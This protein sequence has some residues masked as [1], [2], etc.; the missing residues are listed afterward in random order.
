MKFDGTD[1]TKV[2]YEQ[3]SDLNLLELSGKE[4]MSLLCSLSSEAISKGSIKAW[5][6]FQKE[7]QS[8]VRA[9]I[10]LTF[11]LS[12]DQQHLT[13][14]LKFLNHPNLSIRTATLD[15]LVKRIP[16]KLLKI[17]PKLLLNQDPRIQS[18]A[19]KGLG[20]INPDYAVEYID[21]ILLELDTAN[22]LSA[23]RICILLPFE[24]VKRSL[25]R[26]VAIEKDLELIKKC[27]TILRNNPDI[28][29]PYR[30]WEI[31]E[32]SEPE[33]SELLKTI[34]KGTC[35]NLKNSGIL[36]QNFDCFLRDLQDRVNLSKARKFIQNSLELMENTSKEHFI[37]LKS[38][39]RTALEIDS[40][41]QAL[42][43]QEEW[44]SET[45]RQKLM[46]LGFDLSSVP[47]KTYSFS[48]AVF[49]SSTNEEKVRMIVQWSSE[50]IDLFSSF[51][52]KNWGHPSITDEIRAAI[53]RFA[54]RKNIE[55]FKLYAQQ[56]LKS[57]H[58]GLLASSINYTAQF[59]PDE[60]NLYLGKF[61]NMNSKRVV[62]SAIRALK[63]QD[64]GQAVSLLK[65]L[66]EQS[67]PEKQKIALSCFIHFDFSIVRKLLTNF[68]E[69]TSNLHYLEQAICFYVENE[70]KENLYHL[71][72]IS[73]NPILSSTNIV[74]KANNQLLNALKKRE[75]VSAKEEA[76]LKIKFKQRWE[77]ERKYLT[78]ET[79][80]PQSKTIVKL[81]LYVKKSSL[82]IVSCG[83]LLAGILLLLFL[84]L[85]P[86]NDLITLNNH[87]QPRQNTNSE[88]LVTGIVKHLEPGKIELEFA[89]GENIIIDTPGAILS[90]LNPGDRVKAK[91]YKNS[92]EK[93]KSAENFLSAI[94]KIK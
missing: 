64:P 85:S 58:E 13:Q 82:I 3:F 9:S 94:W 22:K 70:E 39:I 65:T 52:S 18:L 91:F 84:D 46:D 72:C 73:K 76:F 38:R 35:L 12:W 5:Q 44:L 90:W 24:N 41:K 33:K 69:K 26:F 53:L 55:S 31:A 34:I 56:G 2:T 68:L 29:V 20:T 47:I 36:K 28:E 21:L 89:N 81:L 78:P 10:I 7:Q 1:L 80:K 54:T 42:R 37:E 48:E 43:Y 14:L 15:V 30:L 66:L 79:L 40:V 83:I 50:Q 93:G 6:W 71:F 74:Q 32:S 45:C 63:A 8:E 51:F 27:G 59:C 23:L 67:D 77:K 17:L 19:L 88:Q 75:I 11:A 60:L 87:Y 25:L 86:K 16:E 61:L 92:S 57:N 62:S 49:F 4:K